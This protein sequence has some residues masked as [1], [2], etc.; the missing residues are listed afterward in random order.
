MT[1]FPAQTPD[2][3]LGILLATQ[4]ESMQSVWRAVLAASHAP[5]QLN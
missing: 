4:G 5:L 1:G 2:G 3:D